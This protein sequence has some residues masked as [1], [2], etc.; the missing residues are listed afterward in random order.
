VQVKT[1]ETD[2][3]SALQVTFGTK[4]PGKLNKPEAGHFERPAWRRAP[5]SSSCASPT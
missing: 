4:D 3:Y 2:G 1:P 5:R